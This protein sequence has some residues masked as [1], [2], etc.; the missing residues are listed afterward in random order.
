MKLKHSYVTAA[1]KAIIN[2]EWEFESHTQILPQYLH[3]ASTAM[4]TKHTDK[5]IDVNFITLDILC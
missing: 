1:P 3:I 4:T 2:W 5:S